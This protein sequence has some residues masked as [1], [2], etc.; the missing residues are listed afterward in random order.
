MEKEGY[1]PNCLTVVL[2]NA[3]AET[4]SHITLSPRLKK[5]YQSRIV[6]SW[7]GDIA[8]RLFSTFTPVR[9]KTCTVSYLNEYCEGTRHNSLSAQNAASYDVITIEGLRP[10][11]Y[12]F[13]VNQEWSKNS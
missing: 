8:L 13:Y 6:L 10:S 11:M 12:V 2:D 1:H 5:A 4:T 7:Y 3:D 9:S